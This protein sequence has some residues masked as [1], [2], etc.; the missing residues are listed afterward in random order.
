MTTP[1]HVP[2]RR[3]RDGPGVG[4]ACRTCV[5]LLPLQVPV[6]TLAKALPWLLDVLVLCL[7]AFFVF[8]VVAVQLFAGALR[9]RCVPA[10]TV[11]ASTAASSRHW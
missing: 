10:H 11:H 6:A 9:S 1:V 2:S 7:F 3:M 8:G 5:L 4:C